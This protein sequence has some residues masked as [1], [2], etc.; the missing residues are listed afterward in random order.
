MK[1][2]VVAVLKRLHLFFLYRAYKKIQGRI[3]KILTLRIKCPRAYYKNAKKPVDPNKIVFIEVRM[4]EITNSFK[5]LYDEL[6][7]KYNY[8]IH[9]HFLRNTFVP[10]KEYIK[11]CEDMMAD[12]A[13]AK[14]VL[15][16]PAG[17]TPKTIVFFLIASTY[18]FCPTV[19]AFT[20]F[21]LAVTQKQSS[22]K[23]ASSSFL[24]SAVIPIT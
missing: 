15:P 20:G 23:I 9:S 3:V 2:A 19:F 10:L 1:D 6:I 16:V 8:E 18:F 7:T 12:I 4:G 5:L 11:R 14:Y 13:T 17:P 24:P 21:P 22:S